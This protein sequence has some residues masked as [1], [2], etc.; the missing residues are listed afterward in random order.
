MESKN[1]LK[2]IAI[3]NSTCYYFYDI[4]RDIDINFSDSL[5]DKKLS[6]TY[7]DILIYDISYKTF[8][9]SIPLCIRF[10]KIDAF[11]KVYDRIR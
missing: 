7:E 1:E 11:I 3:I 10:D 5:L 9:S 8:M 4:I 6:K 2:E